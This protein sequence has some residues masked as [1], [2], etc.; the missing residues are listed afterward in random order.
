MEKCIDAADLLETITKHA[1]TLNVDE[2]F[3]NTPVN[4]NNKS[5]FGAKRHTKRKREMKVKK[6]TTQ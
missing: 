3:R 5:S 6:Q 4:P 1:A 2:D